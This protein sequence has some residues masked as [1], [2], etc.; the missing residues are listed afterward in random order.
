MGSNAEVAGLL[1]Y[2][3]PGQSPV[4]TYLRDDGPTCNQPPALVMLAFAGESQTDATAGMAVWPSTT[5]FED[6]CPPGS[7]GVGDDQGTTLE[8]LTVNDQPATLY[9][10]NESFR[11]WWVVKGGVPLYGEASGISRAELLAAAESIEANPTRHIVEIGGDIPGQM[12][13]VEQQESLGVWEPGYWRMDVYEIDG[14]SVAVQARYDSSQTPHTRYTAGVAFLDLA[15]VNESPA[16]WIPEG[17]NFLIFQM[18]DNVIV[19]VEGSPTLEQAV[20]VAEDL[21]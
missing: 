21:R 6:T 3:L 20:R 10:H 15:E 9:T 8:D 1:N 13:V 5:R 4:D 7:C 14:T 19:H 17:G 12:Q 16:A 11:L 2:E 18:S